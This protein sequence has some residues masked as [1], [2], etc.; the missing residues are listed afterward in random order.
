M[1]DTDES[2]LN[3]SSGRQI[4]ANNSIIGIDGDGNVGGGY[5]AMIT[6][7][8]WDTE[9]EF[10]SVEDMREL[11]DLMISRWQRFKDTAEARSKLEYWDGYG[12][13][14]KAPSPAS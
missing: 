13:L 11:A 9:E 6:F 12:S 14:P 2:I 5:D 3:F 10:F 1:I 4:Y 8:H 7:Q